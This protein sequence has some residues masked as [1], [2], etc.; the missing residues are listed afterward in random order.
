MPKNHSWK[1]KLY[2]SLI[3]FFGGLLG[4]SIIFVV[5]YLI[6]D[7]ARLEKPFPATPLGLFLHFL[8]LVS[9]VEEGTKF[10]L[11]KRNIGQFPYG[12]L[13]GFGF[14]IGEAILKYPFSEIITNPISKSGAVFLHIITAGI[15]CY[16]IKKNKPISGFLIAII[17]HTTFNLLVY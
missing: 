13:L 17:L 14:G 4:V 10:L 11:I 15:I 8:I 5:F 6:F 2:Y 3:A 16:F 1:N 7:V 9:F 12:F